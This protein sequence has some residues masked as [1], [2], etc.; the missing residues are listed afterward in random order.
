MVQ[1]TNMTAPRNTPVEQKAAKEQ[2]MAADE[3]KH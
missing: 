3:H 2:Q 1:D